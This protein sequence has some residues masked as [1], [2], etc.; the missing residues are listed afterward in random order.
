MTSKEKRIRYFKQLMKDVPEDEP[1]RKA[2]IKLINN[3]SRVL[4]KKRRM[5]D[6]KIL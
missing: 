1:N 6:R 5:S 2:I 3:I 4:R